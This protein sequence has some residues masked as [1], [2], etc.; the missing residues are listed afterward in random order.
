MVANTTTA[1]RRIT[2]AVNTLA[3]ADGSAYFDAAGL[4]LGAD[5]AGT[6]P[7]RWTY[8]VAT[9]STITQQT[10]QAVI[11]ATDDKSDDLDAWFD[12]H[13]DVLGYLAAVVDRRRQ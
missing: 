2:R 9:H 7:T 8:A 4:Y 1:A 11:D 13:R 12:T 10:A 3:G 5:A 6:A